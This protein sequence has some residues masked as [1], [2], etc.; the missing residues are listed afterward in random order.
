MDQRLAAVIQS[1]KDEFGDEISPESRFYV[2]VNI[3]KRAESLGFTEMVDKY[4]DVQAII[5]LK[6]PVSGM[7][8]RIDGRTFVNYAQYDTGV[9][10]PGYIAKKVG[11]PFKTFIPNDSMIL[12]FS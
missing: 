2:E 3:G 11:L 8:V 1:L 9:V 10:V 6:N 4:R 12:N 7:K 5:P